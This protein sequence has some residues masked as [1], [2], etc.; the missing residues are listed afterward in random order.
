MK[1]TYRL[2][3]VCKIIIFSMMGAVF[4]TGCKDDGPNADG[5]AVTGIEQETETEGTISTIDTDDAGNTTGGESSAIAGET[6]EDT[7]VDI[8]ALQEENA[9]IFAWLYIPGTDIDC[10]VL[11]SESADDFYESHNAYGE[12]DGKG[13]AYIELANLTNM[14]DF[15]TVIHGKASADG[16][17]ED[18]LFSDI[19]QFS[20]PDFFEKHKTAYIYLDGNL[21]TYEIFAAYE[22]E[23]TSLL[24]T[25]D[26]TYIAG[27]QEFLDDLYNTRVMGMNFRDGWEDLTPYHFLITLTTQRGDDPEKQ[28]V[29]LGGLVNDAAGTIDRVMYE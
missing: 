8:K 22:R 24:R 20:D 27:C 5:Q 19:Y 4:L 12:P 7:V 6:A 9:D 2:S 29:V 18:G 1:K 28:F 11:Q 26:F 14:C 25:Y 3:A 21:L 16:D 10:P 17:G 15:N 13:A 23:N